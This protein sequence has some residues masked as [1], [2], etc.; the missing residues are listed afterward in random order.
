MNSETHPT[1][2]FVEQTPH[3]SFIFV[4]PLTV[5]AYEHVPKLRKKIQFR[6][7]V[8][9]PLPNEQIECV[10]VKAFVFDNKRRCLCEDPTIICCGDQPQFDGNNS[11][12]FKEL[13]LEKPKNPRGITPC[14]LRFFVK[15]KQ[16]LSSFFS[17]LIKLF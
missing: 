1:L 13:M 6:V 8:C 12:I 5:L 9:L 16:P 10:G 17:L 14:F 4:F 7:D 3:S 15:L 2:R 11:F